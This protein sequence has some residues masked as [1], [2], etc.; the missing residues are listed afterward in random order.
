MRSR[1]YS[2]STVTAGVQNDSVSNQ[3]RE[4]GERRVLIPVFIISPSSSV[5][6]AKE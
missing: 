3:W 1:G 6:V 4:F 2:F 5:T